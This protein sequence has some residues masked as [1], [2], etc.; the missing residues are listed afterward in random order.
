MIGSGLGERATGGFSSSTTPPHAL[1][2]DVSTAVT[3]SIP[4]LMPDKITTAY[5]PPNQSIIPSAKTLLKPFSNG[6][7][8]Y[9]LD[10]L[11][12]FLAAFF[13]AINSPFALFDFYVFDF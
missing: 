6:F 3:R 4:G 2:F 5:T 7:L 8:I 10:F 13:L 12:T 9:F 1:T 11:E